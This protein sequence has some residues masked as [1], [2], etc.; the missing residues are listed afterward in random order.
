MEILNA[1]IFLFHVFLP[2][3]CCARHADFY[4]EFRVF[5]RWFFLQAG[6]FSCLWSTTFKRNIFLSRC[7][8]LTDTS[9]ASS[10]VFCVSTSSQ[11]DITIRYATVAVL[12]NFSSDIIN[13]TAGTVHRQFL[14][15]VNFWARRRLFRAGKSECE[16]NIGASSRFESRGWWV[17]KRINRVCAVRLFGWR[18]RGNF[19]YIHL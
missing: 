3:I 15:P 2:T 16:T 9:T 8:L 7:T 6:A 14:L 10:P 5:W 17:C 19:I 11:A 4:F 18:T 12:C 13:I 1:S